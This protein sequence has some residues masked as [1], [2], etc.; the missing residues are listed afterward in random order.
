MVANPRTTLG[1]HDLRALN[2]PVAL[3]VVASATGR[4]EAVCRDGWRAFVRVVEVQDV[5]RIDDEWWRER[6]ISRLYYR[7]RLE[8]DIDL[9]LYHDL[10]NG[11]WYGQRYGEWKIPVRRFRTRRPTAQQPLTRRSASG[12][13]LAPEDPPRI[14]TRP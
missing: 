1:A 5:W 12:R 4:L 2:A 6:P 7:V 3:E 11:R 9:T 14:P 8:G 13:S 10:V